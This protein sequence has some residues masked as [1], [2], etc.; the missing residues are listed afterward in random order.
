MINLKGKERLVSLSV[1]LFVGVTIIYLLFTSMVRTPATKAENAANELSRKID[2]ARVEINKKDRYL[3]ALTKYA[4]RT[5]G[6]DELDVSQSLSARLLAL[7]DFSGLTAER[8]TSLNPLSGTRAA[9]NYKEVGWT[10]NA[11]GTLA[12]VVKFLCLLQNEP[13]LH[14]VENIRLVPNLRQGDVKLQL[15][16]ISLIMDTPKGFKQPLATMPAESLKLSLPQGQDYQ[17]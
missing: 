12:S 17:P 7:L 4:A 15:R 1:G 14:R 11:N 13:Y 9:N 6:T 16:Y 5:F 3:A 10:V 2:V 8:N